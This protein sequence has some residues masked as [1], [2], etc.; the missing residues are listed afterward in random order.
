MGRADGRSKK[1][2]AQVASVGALAALGDR[3]IDTSRA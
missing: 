3:G 1:I 2:A